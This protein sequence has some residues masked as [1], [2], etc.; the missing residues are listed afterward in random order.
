MPTERM[1]IL[2][3]ARALTAALAIA[4]LGLAASASP[5]VALPADFWG[6]VPQGYPSLEQF[7]RLDRG[8]VES[9]RASIDWA[10]VQPRAG[11][12]FDWSSVD[13][14]VKGAVSAH[15][16]V[17]PFLS[18]APRWAVPEDHR[19]HS[20]ENLPVRSGDQRSGWT[21]FVKAAVL[22]YGPR[23]SFWAENPEV[24]KRPIRVW[25]IWNE[26]NFE[27]FVA[28]PNPAEYGKL[29]KLSYGAIK[30]VDPGAR[31]VLGGL[32][33]KPK[34]ATFR[35]K[36]PLA[37]FAADFL[38][39]MY[40]RTPGIKGRFNGVALHPY[41]GNY[42]YL[43]PYIEEVRD[44]LRANHDAGKQLWLT[45]LGWSSEHPTHGNAFAK[46]PGG[47]KSQLTGAFR[48]LESHQRKWRIARVYWFSVEDQ[49][50]TCNFCGGSGLF[51]EGFVPKPAWYAY[52]HFAGG[53]P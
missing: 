41:T 22:R 4:A 17:L 24:P 2:R 42:K 6:V 53:R 36:P 52:A 8:G 32:F 31:I 50:G 12:P 49:A 13:S 47:Q 1:R 33:S 44:V 11:G 38:E 9:V 18:G 14:I 3:K 43:T 5:A 30:G 27:Y 25:Q 46:G 40:E 20:P 23:G 35:R 10:A 15:L 39:Q 29:V 26:E 45:E 7:Q 34:E 19:Y 37:Y 51:G 16:D 48:L 28:R 21:R